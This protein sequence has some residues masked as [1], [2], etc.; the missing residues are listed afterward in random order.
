MPLNGFSQCI[1]IDNQLTNE[2]KI[3]SKE[4]KTNKNGNTIKIKTYK[5]AY[6]E[7][8]SYPIIGEAAETYKKL[9][10]FYPF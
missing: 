7:E 3:L 6:F 9:G 8:V 10:E 5:V 4:D 2:I 1:L